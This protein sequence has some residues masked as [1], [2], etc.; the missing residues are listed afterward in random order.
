[1]GQGECL[2]EREREQERA[3]QCPYFMDRSPSSLGHINSRIPG[4]KVGWKVGGVI[5]RVCSLS[6]TV[7]GASISMQGSKRLFLAAASGNLVT[8]VIKSFFRASQIERKKIEL[9]LIFIIIELLF[10]QVLTRS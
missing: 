2:K 6:S 9:H 7:P 3:Q 10:S 1:M 4:L 5:E 8:A